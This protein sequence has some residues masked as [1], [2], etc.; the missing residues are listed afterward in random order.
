[1][2]LFI[3]VVCMVAFFILLG[4]G[5]FIARYW[6]KRYVHTRKTQYTTKSWVSI[7]ALTA[8]SSLFL[9]TVGVTASFFMV[10]HNQRSHFESVH[11]ILGYLLYFV[12]AT[13]VPLFGTSSPL[14]SLDSEEEPMNP[15]YIKL[16]RWLGYTLWFVAM[17]NLAL[18][19]YTWATVYAK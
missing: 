12:T 3:H 18:G 9:A 17:F 11:G 16:H 2:L 6:K 8:L 4:S 10:E 19:A 14:L 13:V 5:I 1:M 7:H 15:I